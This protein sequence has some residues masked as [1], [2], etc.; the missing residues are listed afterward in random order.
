MASQMCHAIVR[1]LANYLQ[2]KHKAIM[3]SAALWTFH[4]GIEFQAVHE[5]HDI[6]SMPAMH[7]FSEKSHCA[8]LSSRCTRMRQMI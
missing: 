2:W 1:K 6:W 8:D 5:L 4:L 7:L 3:Q